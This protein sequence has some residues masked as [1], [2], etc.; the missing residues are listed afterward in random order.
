MTWILT[1]VFN[2]SPFLAKAGIVT[3]QRKRQKCTFVFP[4]EGASQPEMKQS[5]S[6]T[7]A[8]L[9]LCSS[10]LIIHSTY[11]SKRG[12]IK[13]PPRAAKFNAT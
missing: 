11:S 13:K 12:L 10:C 8:F 2:N 9:L 7:L 5:V 1:T 4:F 6:L 3:E